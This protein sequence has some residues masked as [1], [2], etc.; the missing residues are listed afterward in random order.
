MNPLGVYPHPILQPVTRCAV[1]PHTIS[2]PGSFGSFEGL[3]VGRF[4][5]EGYRLFQAGGRKKEGSRGSEGC[6]E[7]EIQESIKKMGGKWLN[8]L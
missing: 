6:C 3:G 8:R 1:R 5:E 4:E 7:C 2:F